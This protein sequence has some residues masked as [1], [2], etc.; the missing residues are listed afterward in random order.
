M[1]SQTVNDDEVDASLLDNLISVIQ[2]SNLV[3]R[4][5]SLAK[6][7]IAE[8]FLWVKLKPFRYGDNPTVVEGPFSIN[9]ETWSVQTTLRRRKLSGNCKLECKLSFS[10]SKGTP[11]FRYL[12]CLES[13]TKN[14]IQTWNA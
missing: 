2:Q 4:V 7:N 1:C 12:L 14:P 3:V 8:H 6:D 10:R 13:S 9:H 11:D 5:V